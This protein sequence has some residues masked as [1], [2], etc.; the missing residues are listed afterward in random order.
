MYSLT[1]VV[2]LRFALLAALS[3]RP[4]T[5]YDLI[6]IFDRSVG[7][8]WHAP[9]PQIYPELRRMEADGLAAAREL[10]RGKGVKREYRLTDQGLAELRR[11]AST[12]VE[13][14]HQKDPY[15]LK[16]AYL[17]FADP[18][19]ARQQFQWHA[20]HFT[21]DVERYEQILEAL[22]A[23]TDPVLNERL[24]S[25]PESEH[26]LIQASK[27]FSYEGLLARAEMEVA[28]AQEGLRMLDR[29]AERRV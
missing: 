15:R 29:F 26:E 20:E 10:A 22:H 19:G 1:Y 18:G 9:H 25:M 2:N 24:R 7:N 8:V 6:S 28:W 3:S 13:P 11:L 4:R 21:R 17:E 27:I 12:P 14:A 5:G 16:A 23:G